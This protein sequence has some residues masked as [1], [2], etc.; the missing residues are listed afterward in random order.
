LIDVKTGA[1]LADEVGKEVRFSQTG[2]FVIAVAEDHFVIRDCIDGK[3]AHKQ[4]ADEPRPEYTLVWDDRDSFMIAIGTVNL[5]AYPSYIWS[6]LKEEDAKDTLIDCR[7]EGLGFTNDTSFKI[8]LENNIAV[9]VCY[10]EK[11]ASSVT[12][13]GIEADP[14]QIDT[15]REYG[16]S[17]FAASVVSVNAPNSW[18]MI[19]GLKITHLKITHLEDSVEREVEATLAAYMVRPIVVTKGESQGV[20]DNSDSLRV[21][22]RGLGNFKLPEAGLAFSRKQRLREFGMKINDGAALVKLDLAAL[23][24]SENLL[25]NFQFNGDNKRRNSDK[26]GF[27]PLKNGK[28]EL[29]FCKE[30]DPSVGQIQVEGFQLTLFSVADTSGD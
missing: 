13:K 18:E 28:L 9:P 27:T 3:D 20:H 24:T 12:I 16:D 6:G 21:A 7:I 8:D 25:R 2:R 14:G 10:G 26:C 11:G 1:Q 5:N 17:L 19:D 30:H 22:S 15:Y 29:V 23:K 4:A